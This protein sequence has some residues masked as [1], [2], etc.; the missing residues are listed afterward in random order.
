LHQIVNGR[1]AADIALIHHV[2]DTRTV[3]GI[4]GLQQRYPAGVQRG[5][6]LANGLQ[7]GEILF[8]I[9]QGI[10]ERPPDVSCKRPNIAKTSIKLV[11]ILIRFNM[12]SL[13]S[14]RYRIFGLER[15]NFTKIILNLWFL[16]FPALRY[17]GCRAR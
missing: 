8:V 7:D 12:F 16:L 13:S 1:A 2:A 14:D 11:T 10:K 9:L 17:G 4:T 6:L 3:Q 15:E 5:L